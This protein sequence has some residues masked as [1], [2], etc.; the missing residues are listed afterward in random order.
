MSLQFEPRIQKSSAV[1][2]EL[3]KM[4]K[5]VPDATIDRAR[6][7]A[8]TLGI[9]SLTPRNAQRVTKGASG[10]QSEAN[11]DHVTADMPNPKDVATLHDVVVSPDLRS[12]II[13][14]V[15]RK[16]RAGSY[17]NWEQS[18]TPLRAAIDDLI[19][20]EGI[21]F[22]SL[23]RLLGSKP[24]ATASDDDKVEQMAG[25]SFAKSDLGGIAQRSRDID[26]LMKATMPESL[27]RKAIV[28]KNAFD[29]MSPVVRRKMRA[30]PGVIEL[31]SDIE[32]LRCG[33]QVAPAVSRLLS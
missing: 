29:D 15:K 31:L 12:S 23:H 16:Q 30:D 11:T 21:K 5:Y 32:G 1:F 7:V 27:R 6:R 17:A 28:L 18:I 22:Q 19:E 25:R 14:A 20:R 4:S 3:A 2:D 26:V 8:K 9:E 10:P 33:A 13:E 24:V